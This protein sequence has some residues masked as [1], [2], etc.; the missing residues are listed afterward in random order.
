M[1][2]KLIILLSLETVNESETRLVDKLMKPSTTKKN[3]FDIEMGHRCIMESTL[4]KVSKT[5]ITLMVIR[6]VCRLAINDMGHIIL[7]QDLL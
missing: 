5:G 4:P 2:R 7:D 3:G 1:Y 6:R